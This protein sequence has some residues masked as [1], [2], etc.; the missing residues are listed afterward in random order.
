MPC[1]EDSPARE[2]RDSGASVV[3]LD[4]EIADLVPSGQTDETGQAEQADETEQ[5]GQTG[6]ADAIDQL[7]DED[8]KLGDDAFAQSPV[9]TWVTT[10]SARADHPRV[11][12]LSATFVLALVVGVA[13]QVGGSVVAFAL[14]IVY[15]LMSAGWPMLMRLPDPVT[16]GAA[17]AF[18]GV[19][20][21]AT[22]AWSGAS[23]VLAYLPG[24]VAL[25]LF[26][27]LL[28]EFARGQGRPRL[29]ESVTG[30]VCG[31]VIQA[32][33]ATMIATVVTGHAP[34]AIPVS[35]AAVAG[36]LLA[37]PLFLTRRLRF[38][39][40]YLTLIFGGIA[41]LTVRMML[42]AG[43]PDYKPLTV[44]AVSCFIAGVAYLVRHVFSS[45]PTIYGERVQL[46]VA[47]ATVAAVGFPGFLVFSS[48]PGL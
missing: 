22:V 9:L 2:V 25:S 31:Q 28:R 23:P 14:A 35:M 20:S 29:V 32:S 47:A 8:T 42:S 24:V 17:V 18:C 12:T 37:E 6:Q 44:F 36:G 40:P 30:T 15:V 43:A 26:L 4:T 27:A 7:A 41:G 10:A 46:S 39:A 19:A 48:L 45:Q 16:A 5:A 21:C 13:A 1:P 33:G 38:L 34:L 11:L 3:E